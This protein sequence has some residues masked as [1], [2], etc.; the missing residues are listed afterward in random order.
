M[1]GRLQQ[2]CRH[3][4]RDGQPCLTY[5]HAISSV[6]RRRCAGLVR[7]I[8]SEFKRTHADMWEESHAPKFSAEELSALQVLPPRSATLE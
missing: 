2:G 6:P 7:K 8:L 4:L 1:P 3:N 5:L